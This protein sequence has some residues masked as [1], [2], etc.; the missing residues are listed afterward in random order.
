MDEELAA[1]TDRILGNQP[2]EE[3]NA[4]ELRVLEN[5]VSQLK[6]AMTNPS[7]EALMQRIEKQ[8][9][10]EW[11]KNQD[12]T[13]KKPSLWQKLLPGSP[14]WRNRPQRQLLFAFV[15]IIFFLIVVL[16]ISQII[17]PNLQASAGG[18]NQYQVVLFIMAILLVIGLIWFSRNKS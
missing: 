13:E 15:I 11:N 7:S 16:P 4:D 6:N 18:T 1:F 10:N 12:S 3:A 17:T 14:F 2:V 9:V 5:T 8:L